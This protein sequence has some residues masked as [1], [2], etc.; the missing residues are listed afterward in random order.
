[1]LKLVLLSFLLV[2]ISG[3]AS[4]AGGEPESIAKRRRLAALDSFELVGDGYCAARAGCNSW[5]CQSSVFWRNTYD[6]YYGTVT[7]TCAQDALDAGAQGFFAGTWPFTCQI[8]PQRD[9]A[10][11]RDQASCPHSSFGNCPAPSPYGNVHSVD[12]R[13]A[14]G[15]ASRIR[16]VDARS[17]RYGSCY[18]ARGECCSELTA[19]CLSC[20]LGVTEVDYCKASPSTDGCACHPGNENWSCCSSS[21]PCRDGF[22]DCDNDSDC[23]SSFCRQDVI[24]SFDVCGR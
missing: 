21:R 11:L 20:Q 3:A 19:L 4:G 6:R 22:G 16:G 8:V 23:V 15:L 24:G 10:G 14:D 13:W 9:P 5:S 1:M 7:E 18:R 2:I 17:S 12:W